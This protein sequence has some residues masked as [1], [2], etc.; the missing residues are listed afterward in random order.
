MLIGYR[1]IHID[2]MDTSTQSQT[3]NP[4]PKKGE[5]ETLSLKL[6]TI[7]FRGDINPPNMYTLTFEN[8]SP[9]ARRPNG[10]STGKDGSL[11]IPER[12]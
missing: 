8:R 11:C 3:V 6:L 10:P 5:E 1:L 12:A 2:R 9:R 7:P 4:K